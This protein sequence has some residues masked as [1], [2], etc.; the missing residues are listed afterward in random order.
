MPLLESVFSK[1]SGL[2]LTIFL[3]VESIVDVFPG[4]FQNI[5]N[6]SSLE[7]LKTAAYH[8]FALLTFYELVL[9]TYI[10]VNVGALLHTR[11]NLNH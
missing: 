1:V 5:Q 8:S 3:K 4:L 6:S 10:K 9:L 2:S 11:G 7:H